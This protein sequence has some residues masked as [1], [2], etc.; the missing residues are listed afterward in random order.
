MRAR[1]KYRSDSL[2]QW[3]TLCFFVAVF[4]FSVPNLSAQEADSS[5]LSLERIYES[6]EFY[7]AWFGPARWLADGRGYTTL[8]ASET[9]RGRDIVRYD[10]RTG[11]RRIMISASHLIPDDQTDPLAIRDYIWSE[12]GEKLMIFTN[13]RRVWRYHTRGDYWVLDLETLKLERMGRGLEPATLMFA[14]FAPDGERVAYV[15]DKNIYVENIASGEIISIT[16]DGGGHIING[17]FDWLY[18]EEL[19]LQDGFRWSPDGKHIAYW[20]MDTEGIGTFHMINNLDSLYPE[21]IPI[22]YPKVGTV[23][24]ASRIGVVPAVGGETRW[25]HISG[26]SRNHYLARVEWAGNSRE[27]FIQQLNRLQNT[28]NVLLADIATAE[29]RLV[30]AETDEAWVEVT[31]DVYWIGDGGFFTWSSERDGWNHLY[32][33]SRDGRDVRLLTDGAYDIIRLLKIDERRNRFYF[34]ASPENATERYLFAA[35]LDG[36][37]EVVQLTPPEW[38]GHHAYQ[39]SPDC[40]WAIHTHSSM[41]IP[42]VIDL[43]RLN[44]HSRVRVLEEN[45]RLQDK[46]TQLHINQP[47]YFRIPV[48]EDVE[49][50]GWMIKP[51]DFNS[52][53]QYPVFFYVYGEPAASTTQNRWGGD[54]YL[55][56]QMLAQQGYVVMSIDNRGTNMPRGRDWRKC[57]YKKIG[58]VAPKDQAAAAR[59]IM[60]WDFVDPDRIGIW[61]WSGGGSMTLN[62]MFRYPEIY[63]TGIAVAF[64]SDQRLYDTCYQERYMGL[65]DMNAAGFRDGSPITYAHR[66]EGDLHIVHGTGDD[67]VHYQNFEWLVDELV[68]QKKQFSMMAYPMRSHGI[69]E[70]ENTTIHLRTLMT[71]YLKSHLEPGP[72]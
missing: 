1:L 56:H 44:G 42:P 31:D 40:R 10:T 12:D 24:P 41:T 21:L 2:G 66:L 11:R 55:W 48:D 72:R 33:V 36:R 13:T 70:R 16:E 51:P 34:I 15:S 47:E 53:K 71:D 43:V 23:N 59:K 50:D 4:A 61:G 8:E 5:L 7:P 35:P 46:L 26:D 65:P 32:L 39:I 62:C 38:T 30:L 37:G 68:K 27:L 52:S 64:V 18:E 19:G 25:M 17:T 57:I 67:N 29:T 20:Q 3:A 28:N 9:G 60:T 6:V 63:R 54:T 14:K 69:Y 22:P 58:I 49:L 45:T